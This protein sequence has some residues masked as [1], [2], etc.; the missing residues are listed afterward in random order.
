MTVGLCNDIHLCFVHPHGILSW[1]H[2]AEPPKISLQI[3]HQWIKDK[4]ERIIV[5]RENIILTINT[6]FPACRRHRVNFGL[7]SLTSWQ[8]NN[9]IQ[10]FIVCQTLTTTHIISARMCHMFLVYRQMI[11]LI[12]I[13]CFCLLFTCLLEPFTII[14]TWSV[15]F[16]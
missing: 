2:V 6:Y 7:L 1:Q 13:F 14:C 9:T 11:T 16:L 15:N 12:F 8:N 10:N 5:T 4:L 3:S